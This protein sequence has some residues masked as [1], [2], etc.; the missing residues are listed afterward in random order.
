MLPRACVCVC[1]QLPP[2]S[3]FLAVIKS[4]LSFLPWQQCAGPVSVS[5]S[6]RFSLSRYLWCQACW[7]NLELYFSN[8]GDFFQI[9]RHGYVNW[10]KLYLPRSWI[11]VIVYYCS[12]CW[13][14]VLWVAWTTWK[15]S[16]CLYVSASAA[17]VTAWA[18]C[19]VMCCISP[20]HYSCSTLKFFLP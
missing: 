12:E 17:A 15:L 10:F 14:A 4:S 6:R 16:P 8:L 20:K 13:A 2:H 11:M 1:V 5:P 9:Y 3:L 7:T 18:T 19:S